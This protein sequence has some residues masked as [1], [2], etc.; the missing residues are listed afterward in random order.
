MTPGFESGRPVAVTQDNDL[1]FNAWRTTAPLVYTRKDGTV[2]T[3]EP[4]QDTDFTSTPAALRWCVDELTGTAAAIL[5]DH[6]WR[7]LV[8]SGQMSYRA[9]DHLLL[10]ALEALQVAGPRRYLMFAA[11]R[12]G[13]LFTRR[14]GHIGWWRDAP[15][16]LAI[17][18]PGLFLA[19]FALPLIIPLSLL[20]AADYM[21]TTMRTPRRYR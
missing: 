8:P 3:V 1:I 6:A 16:V 15:L 18:V 7:R 12:L 19:A 14:G 5:H 20:N 21:T 9:A 17:A 13:S 11:V 4:G 2:I 10:E